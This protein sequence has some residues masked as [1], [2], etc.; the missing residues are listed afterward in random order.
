MEPSAQP[1]LLLFLDKDRCRG[2]THCLRVCP[3]EA[4]RIR[5]GK[6]QAVGH[7]CVHC[8]RCLQVCPQKAWKGFSPSGDGEDFSCGRKA[9]A[10]LDSAVFWQFGDWV[11]PEEVTLAFQEIGFRVVENMTVSLAVYR[12]QVM[13]YLASPERP[14]PAIGSTCPAVVE[15]VRVKYPSLIENLVPTIS[16]LE[17]LMDQMGK[18]RKNISPVPLFFK[19]GYQSTKARVGPDSQITGEA[20]RSTEN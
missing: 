3:T 7:R 14:L 5:G 20:G 9:I 12:N 13:G 10:I 18:D 1:D 16:P 6:A 19:A 17:I 11:S 4:I 8:G 15:F 2:C